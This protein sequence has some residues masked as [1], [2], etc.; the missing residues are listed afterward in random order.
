VEQVENPADAG[1]SLTLDAL[2]DV[3]APAN[4]PP[5]NFL[6][7]TAVGTW[8]PLP[9]PV[10]PIDQNDDGKVLT[11]SGPDAVWAESAAM[12]ALEIFG[13]ASL[14]L[15]VRPEPWQATVYGS[16]VPVIAQDAAG[17]LDY[18]I[19]VAATGGAGP[20]DVPGISPK[21][22]RRVIPD[23]A[24]RWKSWTGTQAQYD[25]VAVKDPGPLYAITG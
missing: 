19:W 5:L 18:G 11:V 21:W 9:N 6:G 15:W 13:A 25:A 7:T 12:N 20:T 22:V 14:G 3:T 2:K 4:T 16:D 17:G 1:S 10:P 24:P 8:G 23:D